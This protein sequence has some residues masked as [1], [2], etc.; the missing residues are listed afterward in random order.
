MPICSAR[1]LKNCWRL[2]GIFLKLYPQQ[3]SEEGEVDMARN[4]NTWIA[5]VTSKGTT[6]GKDGEMRDT[7]DV[8]SPF[9]TSG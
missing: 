6:R 9:K 7:V 5:K 1:L 4:P 8:Y 2:T 3:A